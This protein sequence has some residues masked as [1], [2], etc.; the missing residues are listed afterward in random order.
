MLIQNIIGEFEFMKSNR[1]AHPLLSFRWAFR[2][3]VHV[4]WHL[5]VSLPRNCPLGV[6]KLVAAVI[7]SNNVHKQD[8][9]CR[10]IQPIYPHFERWKHP[11]VAKNSGKTDSYQHKLTEIEN[12]RH[13]KKHVDSLTFR[14]SLTSYFKTLNMSFANILCFFVL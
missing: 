13:T 10:F 6:L 8:I 4:L 1:L 9:L 12:T 7:D 11:P 3:D 14:N 5:W 2:V